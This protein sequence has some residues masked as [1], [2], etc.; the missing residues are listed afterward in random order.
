MC[1][2]QR[3]ECSN[4]KQAESTLPRRLG[5]SERFGRDEPIWLA[6]HMCIEA[7]LGIP[8]HSFL[9]LKLTKYYVFLIISYLFS[10]TK[11]ENKKAEQVLSGSVC[12]MGE[13]VQT[14]YT[15][16]SKCKNDTNI[17]IYLYIYV[18]II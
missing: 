2:L 17:Y 14:M 6:L 7:I 8:L 10:S 15:Y 1:S 13:L 12:G 18:Y 9:Y 3:S 5:S 16:V 4:L 11:S